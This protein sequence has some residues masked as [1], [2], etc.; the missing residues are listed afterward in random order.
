MPNP[1]FSERVLA[2][3]T[4]APRLATE[5]RDTELAT[6]LWHQKASELGSPPPV[7]IYR[8]QSIGVTGS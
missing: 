2:R 1:E 6:T 5:R 7:S 8:A 4:E 3:L